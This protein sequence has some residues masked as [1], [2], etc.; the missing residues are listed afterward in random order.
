METGDGPNPGLLGL[1]IG[2]EGFL[3]KLKSTPYLLLSPCFRCRHR[4]SERWSSC[5]L[6]RPDSGP[7]LSGQS[8][9][10]LA[11]S[12]AGLGPFLLVSSWGSWLKGEQGLDHEGP[13]S[14]FLLEVSSSHDGFSGGETASGGG[15]ARKAMEEWEFARRGGLGF[16]KPK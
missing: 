3:D 8:R 13:E 2:E 9:G 15:V 4:G 7:G 6:R 5:S 12:T 10:F 1:G 16:G 14:R 11:H